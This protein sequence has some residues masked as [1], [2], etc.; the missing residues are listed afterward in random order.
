[1]SDKSTSDTKDSKLK[2]EKNENSSQKKNYH[3]GEKL[4]LS[5]EKKHLTLKAV[6]QKANVSESL[7]SQI[8]HNKVSPAIDTLL[9]LANVLDINLEYLFEEYSRQRPV[10]IIRGDER[11]RN[12][13]EN[14]I[15][16]EIS[17][18]NHAVDLSLESYIVTIPENSHT[19]RGNYG[20]IGKVAFP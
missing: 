16:E 7:I 2:S 9:T 8:E 1:M 11:R 15:Y 5:R 12:T 19:H 18:P 13:E 6:A 14:I 10:T 20:H 3:F 4:R 17:D